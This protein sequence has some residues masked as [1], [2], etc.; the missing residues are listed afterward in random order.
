MALDVRRLRVLREVATHGSFSAAA[1]SL[2]F[3]QPAISRQIATLEAETG[4]RLVERN[5]RGIRLTPAGE[6]LVEHA[7]AILDR[8]QVAEAQLEQLA[9][10]DGGRLRLGAFATANAT[11]IPL[12]I[13]AFIGEY[14]RVELDLAEGLSRDLLARLEEG[15]IDVA[16]VADM[17]ATTPHADDIELEP[18]M[19]DAMYIAMPRD[20]KLARRERLKL[21]DFAGETWIEGRDSAC[22]SVLRRSAAAAGFEPNIA[23]ESTQWL[24]K[25]GLV[26]AGV[27]VTLIP[28]V[29][30]A[31]VREDIAIRSLG[32]AGPRRQIS[33]AS[34]QCGYRSPAIEPMKAILR[35]VTEQ[36]CFACDAMVDAVAA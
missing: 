12:A 20:H 25:Q 8:L 33:I 14:P 13:S 9:S 36:H 31:S 11:L 27:G 6:L 17:D 2:N 21:A 18:L 3:T 34:L 5:A 10:L 4:Q 23:Y 7:D 35:R 19:E 1:D 24:G 15:E 28:A 30:L 32:P 29:A 26:A 16:V 22:A